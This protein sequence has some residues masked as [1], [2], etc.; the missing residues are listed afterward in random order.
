M[1]LNPKLIKSLTQNIIHL[2]IFSVQYGI[3]NVHN[4]QKYKP[5]PKNFVSILHVILQLTDSILLLASTLLLKCD[6][7][8]ACRLN[9]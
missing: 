8:I 1:T 2:K 6:S 3:K 4:R 9:Q 5:R 7:Y